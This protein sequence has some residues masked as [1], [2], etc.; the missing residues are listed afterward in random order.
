VTLQRGAGL[1]TLLLRSRLLARIRA[2][3]AEHPA[4]EVDTASLSAAAVTDPAIE[5]LAVGG[6]CVEGFLHTSPEYMMKR[7]ISDGAGDVFQICRVWRDGELGRWHEPEFTM[8]EWYRLG[9]DEF[10]LMDEVEALLGELLGPG[11]LRGPASR[12]RYD[13]ALQNALGLT[14]AADTSALASAL[15][16]RGVDVPPNVPH[17]ALLDLAMGTLASAGFDRDRLTFVHAYPASQAALARIRATD[18][19]TAARFEVFIGPL[20]LGNGF[21]EL[22]DATEQRARFER[23]NAARSSAGR[24]PMPIDEQFLES[25]ELGLPDC[26][27][28]ALGFDRI[29]AAATDARSIADVVAFTH[30]RVSP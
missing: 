3:F 10:A 7:L 14:S 30:A 28:V 2:W 26:A 19:P 15:L 5:S 22:T 23:E 20:E 25:L 29:V 16:A 13:T 21:W 9:I 27:G 6:R 12:I 1:D 17:D 4:L 8:L 24:S 11:R 18:P